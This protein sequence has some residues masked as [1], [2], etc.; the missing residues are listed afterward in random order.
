MREAGLIINEKAKIHC[1]D[2]D[3]IN[4][5]IFIPELYLRI[6][7]KLNGIFSHFTTRAPTNEEVSHCPTFFITPDSAYWDPYSKHYSLNEDA[8]VDWEG[9]IVKHIFKIIRMQSRSEFGDCD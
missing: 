1:S 9:S 2:P 3:I 5:S 6:P 8:L 4:H 7:L